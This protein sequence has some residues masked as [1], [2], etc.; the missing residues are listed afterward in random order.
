[1]KSKTHHFF[2]QNF[3]FSYIYFMKVTATNIGK[4]QE[5]IWRGKKVVTGIFKSPVPAGIFLEAEDVLDD[6]VVDRKYHG[7]IDKACYAYSEDYYDH[8]KRLYPK[9]DWDFGMFG[10]NLTLSNF[11]ERFVSIGDTFQIGEAIV[12]VSEPRQPCFKLNVRFNSNAMVKAFMAFGHCGTYFRVLQNGWV[13][14]GDSLQI[15]EKGTPQLSV[16]DVFQL[17]SNKGTAENK[18]IAL[19]H[20]QLAK[21]AIEALA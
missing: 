2:Y 20:P 21:T 5:V 17:L 7:G 19:T 16:Y 9:L 6:A 12:Q 10:E 1:M 18:A 13:R 15:I 14:P 8:W 3:L 4:K 11:D